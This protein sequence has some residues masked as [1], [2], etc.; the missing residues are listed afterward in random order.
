MPRPTLAKG[1][2]RLDRLTSNF[3]DQRNASAWSSVLEQIESGQMPPKAIPRRP[4]PRQQQVLLSWIKTSLKGADFVRSRNK[5][6]CLRPN[7]LLL[8]V[9]SGMQSISLTLMP[10]RRMTKPPKSYCRKLNGR[11]LA[12]D[13]R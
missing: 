8:Q 13:P 1:D 5:I 12:C 11:R 3:E 6:I 10:S 2:V 9:K 4:D 7:M